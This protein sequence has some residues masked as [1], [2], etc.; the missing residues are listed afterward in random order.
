MGSDIQD[1]G[2]VVGVRVM[3]SGLLGGTKRLEFTLSSG[4]APPSLVTPETELFLEP[5]QPPLRNSSR[6]AKLIEPEETAIIYRRILFCPCAGILQ[7]WGA[8]AEV[9]CRFSPRFP[10]SSAS[11]PAVPKY[12][13]QQN[14][15]TA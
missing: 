15:L 13:L 8:A 11:L 1:G 12:G 9:G 3:L 6:L 7:L 14:D 5:L 4:N 2:G 10:R